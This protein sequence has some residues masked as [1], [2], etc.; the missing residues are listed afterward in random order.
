MATLMHDETL[1]TGQLLQIRD[2]VFAKRHLIPK[3]MNSEWQQL[4]D[5]TSELMPQFVSQTNNRAQYEGVKKTSFTGS[6]NELMTML[7]A[8]TRFNDKLK[9]AEKKALEH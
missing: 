8:L 5:K 2:K 7:K 3:S 9:G 4:L 1:V 6:M